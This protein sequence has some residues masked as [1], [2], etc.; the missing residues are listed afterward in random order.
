[1]TTNQDCGR[2]LSNAIEDN[3]DQADLIILLWLDMMEA[4]LWG[5]LDILEIAE[6][7]LGAGH[8]AMDIVRDKVSIS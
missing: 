7:A 2:V 4:N 5:G 1:M 8:P 6:N 3:P